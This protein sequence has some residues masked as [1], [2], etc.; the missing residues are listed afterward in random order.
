MLNLA[1]TLYGVKPELE[2]DPITRLAINL[3][4]EQRS[5]KSVN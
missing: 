1:R 3:N 5:S 4:G 2:E